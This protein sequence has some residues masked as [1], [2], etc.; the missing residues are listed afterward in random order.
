MIQIKNKIGTEIKELVVIA[1]GLLLYALAWDLFLIPHQ[2]AGG[3]AT[4]ISAIVMYATQGLL[5]ASLSNFFESL[6]MHSLNGGIPVSVTYFVINVVLLIFSV[7]TLGLK[8]SLRTIFGVFALTFWLWLPVQD[9]YL[10]A[11]GSKFPVFDPFMSSII[12]GIIAGIGLGFSFTNNGSSGGTDIIAKI[13]NKYKPSITLGRALLLTDVI[14]ISSSGFLPTGDI[15]HVVYGLIMMFTL[16]STMDM[17]IN[18]TRQSV[19][20]L[21]FSKKYVEIADTINNDIHR[22][23]TVL[24]GEGWYSKQPTKV[25]TVLARKSE[26]P[27]IF[28]II[29]NIDPDAFISQSA[30]IGVYGRGFDPVTRGS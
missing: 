19:Q 29:Q 2:I 8:F 11:F 20:F 22:G 18:G 10:K 26:S 21:I 30:A 5:P 15:T 24:D 16:S 28:K 14:I 13:L 27:R 3:G 7:R 9:M 6:G 12:G 25:L 4:G 17:Y 23:V 1:F